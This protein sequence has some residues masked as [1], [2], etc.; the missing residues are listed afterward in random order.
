[1]A[2]PFEAHPDE[3]GARDRAMTATIAKQNDAALVLVVVGRDLA[4]HAAEPRLKVLVVQD[5]LLDV[6]VPAMQEQS[7]GVGR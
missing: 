2:R 3:L 4:V 5:V 7:F 1:M 6:V